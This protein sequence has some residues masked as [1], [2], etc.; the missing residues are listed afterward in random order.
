MADVPTQSVN[1]GIGPEKNIEAQS[2]FASTLL[3]DVEK[4]R[5]SQVA[6]SGKRHGNLYGS[7]MDT[8]NPQAGVDPIYA[9]KAQLL[10]EALLDIGMGLYQWLLFLVTS[11]GWFLDYVSV[12]NSCEILYSRLM[13]PV[14]DGLLPHHWPILSK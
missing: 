2:A 4:T 12:M 13:Q 14:L 1:D 11:M 7:K 9:A 5:P 8:S 3:T 6:N 10:N